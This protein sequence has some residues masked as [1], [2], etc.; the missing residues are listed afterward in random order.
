VTDAHRPG[1]DERL[2]AAGL[3]PIPR[4]AWLE[5]DLEALADNLA[6]LRVLAGGA[7]MHP[8]VKADAY[9]HGAVPIALALAAAG[10][11]GFCV[12]AIDEAIA[13]RAGGIRAPIRVLYPIPPAFAADAAR[14]RITVA[15]GD[16]GA[17]RR[18][19]A[20][21][22]AAGVGSRGRRRLGIEL[23]VETGL[24]RGGVM[25]DEV[26]AAAQT[27]RA[28]SS[29]RLVALWTHLQASEDAAITARQ[30]ARL[31]QAGAALRAARIPVPPRHVAASGGLLTDVAAF[32]GVRPGLSVYGILPDE[33]AGRTGSAAAAAA[34]DAFRPV[35]SL[36][37]RP[38][39]VADLPAGH[40]ISYGPTFITSRPSRIATLPLGYGDGFGRANSN[41]ATA[42]VRGQRV[43]QVGNVAMDAL[44][45]D[46]TDVQGA[47]VTTDDEFVLLGAQGA[48]RIRAED[49]ALTRTTNTWEVLTQMSGRLPRVYHAAAGAVGLRTLAGWSGAIGTHRTLER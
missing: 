45:I 23:E 41:R 16:A 29:A 44:M 21:A 42:L 7:P 27:I 31:E 37:A 1:I 39:R 28:S 38:V 10:A 49:L 4:T 25:P 6:A 20:G 36:H 9:G 32:D 40:G 43:P 18:L 30:M 12:A 17:L 35:M 19:L 24:G 47:P 22:A 33:L 3:P 15:A 46:V 5:L 8:V 2:A 34:S 11:E 14:R 48:D 13:L 26:V